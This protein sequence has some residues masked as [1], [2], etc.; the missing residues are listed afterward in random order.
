LEKIRRRLPANRQT[1]LFSATFPDSIK[2]IAAKFLTDPVNISVGAVA[3]PIAEIHQA[4]IRTTTEKKNE[5][6]LDEVNTRGGSVLIFTRTKRRTDRL[7]KYLAQYGH[8]VARIHGDRSQVQR[9]SAMQD[10][11][12]G[13]VRIL[14]ATDIAARGIDIPHIAHVIN[15]DLP[16]VPEDYVHRIGRT[17]RAGAKGSSLCLILPEDHSQ[18][19][20][21]AH[22]FSGQD[23]LGRTRPK[24]I[25]TI[26]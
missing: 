1:L 11:R 8:S 5:V 25:S 20:K 24:S 17:A 26:H 14:V 6:L 2:D 19:Q 12:S 18:W 10:F 15:Y 4:V 13:D 9:K 7:A 23:K 21:I 22:M 3:Q 16:Q